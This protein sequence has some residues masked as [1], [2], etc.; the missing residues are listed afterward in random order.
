LGSG[1]RELS[2]ALLPDYVKAKPRPKRPKNR[3]R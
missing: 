3:A 2:K 1:E